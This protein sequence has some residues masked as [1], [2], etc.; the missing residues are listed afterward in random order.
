MGIATICGAQNC[1]I[2]SAAA[3]SIPQFC[4]PQ[5]V[6]IPIP[7]CE[8]MALKA[9]LVRDYN[10][11]IPVHQWEDRFLVRLSCQGYNTHSQMDLLVRAL[12]DLLGLRAQERRFSLTHG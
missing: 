2:E 10:I 3:L 7:P 8:P 9:A 12:S 4:A 5:M 11:E 1:G 6:A